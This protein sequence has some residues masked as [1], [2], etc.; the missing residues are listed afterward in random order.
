MRGF[1]AKCPKCR[2]ANFTSYYKDSE[3]SESKKKER[4]FL[5]NNCRYE[6]IMI[7]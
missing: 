5:C 7:E 1:P 2:T 3:K 4:W 6:E